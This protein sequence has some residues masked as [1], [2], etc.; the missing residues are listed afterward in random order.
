M[1]Q[2]RIL[3]IKGKRKVIINKGGVQPYDKEEIMQ[4]Y[5]TKMYISMLAHE[6]EQHNAFIK[7]TPWK[8]PIPELHRFKIKN[9]LRHLVKVPLYYIRDFV[10]FLI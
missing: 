2:T 4:H 5:D 6:I 9:L 3:Y 10:L 1:S 8:H 7:H